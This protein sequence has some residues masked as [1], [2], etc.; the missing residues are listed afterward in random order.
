MVSQN[1]AGI[2]FEGER[3]LVRLILERG[4]QLVKGALVQ[5]I[6]GLAEIARVVEVVDEQVR[7]P[8]PD[9]ALVVDAQAGGGVR[10]EG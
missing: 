8:G 7:A 5:E 2:D 3:A 4:V 9:R 10:R 1:V 6:V